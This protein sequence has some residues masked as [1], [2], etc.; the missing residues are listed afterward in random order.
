MAGNNWD[1]DF[2]LPEPPGEIPDELPEQTPESEIN[3]IGSRP[4]AD[5]PTESED[6]GLDDAMDPEEEWFWKEP[7][8]FWLD[9]DIWPWP[10]VRSSRAP[11]P[12][13]PRK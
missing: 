11:K 4:N 8:N 9:Q 3:E 2:S 6:P 5:A 10:T 1:K 13:K 12:E 7:E